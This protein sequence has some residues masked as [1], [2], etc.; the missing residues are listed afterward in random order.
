MSLPASSFTN[1]FVSPRHWARLVLLAGIATAAAVGWAAEKKAVEKQEAEAVLRRADEAFKLQSYETALREVDALLKKAPEPKIAQAARRIQGLSYV[2]LQRFDAGLQTLDDLVRQAPGLKGDV[3]I[4]DAQATCAMETSPWD[5]PPGV[6]AERVEAAVKA[7]REQKNQPRRLSLLFRLGD[8]QKQRANVGMF[9]AGLVASLATYERI[10]AD[11]VSADDQ[12]RALAAQ[13][14]AVR[15]YY[16]Q[17]VNWAER[18]PGA[19]P[20]PKFDVGKP[21]VVVERFEREIVRRF[22]EAASAPGALLRIGEF[23]N[24]G[25]PNDY[26]AA[27]KVFDELVAK[28]PTAP[29]AKS[30]ADGA[31][32]IKAPRLA[33]SLV[34]VVAPGVKPMLNWSA[35]NAPTVELSAYRVDLWDVFTKIGVPD[36]ID[37]YPLDGLKPTAQWKAET[38]ARDF[39]PVQHDDK[40]RWTAPLDAKGAYIVVAKGKNA[41]G[42]EATARTFAI[43]GDLAAVAKAADARTLLF[44]V[45]ATTGK[46]RAGAEVLSSRLTVNPDNG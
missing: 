13:A 29:E 2:R 30:A 8:F 32:E 35:R 33:V 4:L 31:A 14:E 28:Y 23:W 25:G 10:L 34:D 7:W 39:K 17:L 26:V 41:Q 16:S 44:V 45:D 22:P 19:K 6:V 37:L 27:L 46:P 11:G 12:V 24:Q 42:A 38:G 43:V 40:T 5:Q 36:R 9:P 18:E 15:N 1:P 21:A 3:E 20:D